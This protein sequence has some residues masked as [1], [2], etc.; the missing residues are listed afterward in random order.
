M[1]EE[2]I[3]TL[4]EIKAELRRE[5]ATKELIAL[6]EVVKNNIDLRGERIDAFAKGQ[7]SALVGVFT[8]ISARIRNLTK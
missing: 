6:R 4:E 2:T 1:T 3:T 5:G 8:E 7:V